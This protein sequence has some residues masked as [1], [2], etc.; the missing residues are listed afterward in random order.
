M[1]KYRIDNKAITALL[2]TNPIIGSKSIFAKIKIRSS[3]FFI[4]VEM[5]QQT[6]CFA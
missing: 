4:V 3:S 2:Q 1:V 5:L 6:L